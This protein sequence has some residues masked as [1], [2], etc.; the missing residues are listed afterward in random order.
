MT[1]LDA[2]LITPLPAS[3]SGSATVR[4]SKKIN[5]RPQSCLCLTWSG[6]LCKGRQR[7]RLWYGLSNNICTIARIKI[8]KKEFTATRNNILFIVNEKKFSQFFEAESDF[9][10]CN[11]ISGLLS[12][13][14]CKFVISDWIHFIYSPKQ[15]LKCVFCMMETNFS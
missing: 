14:G 11:N 13:L 4:G 15:S 2:G 5:P 1:K 7:R 12:A 10:F 9:V 6:Y 8:K 3:D